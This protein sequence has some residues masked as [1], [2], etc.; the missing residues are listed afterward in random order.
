MVRLPSLKLIQYFAPERWMV[1]WFLW[2]RVAGFLG[3]KCTPIDSHDGTCGAQGSKSWTQVFL[4][5]LMVQKSGVHQLMLVYI[6]HYLQ[7][8]STIPGGWPWDFWTINDF[9]PIKKNTQMTLVI[10]ISLQNDLVVPGCA[11]RSFAVFIV[12]GFTGLHWGWE[13]GINHQQMIKWLNRTATATGKEVDP[14][15][16]VCLKW[17]IQKQIFCSLLDFQSV[18]IP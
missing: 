12:L 16:A 3:G 18:Y 11:S 4:I 6:S 9:S 13:C 15:N 5:L 10:H 17:S 2:I 14:A 8:F 7:G 1:G